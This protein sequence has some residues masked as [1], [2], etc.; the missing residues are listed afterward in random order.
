M[1]KRK[2][3]REKFLVRETREIDETTA[4]DS[5]RVSFE[6]EKDGRYDR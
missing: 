6:D 1:V 4:G 3:K 5:P 2:K